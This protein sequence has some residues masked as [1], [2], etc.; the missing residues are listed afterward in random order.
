[1]LRDLVLAD[2]VFFCKRFL[3]VFRG[4]DALAEE[5]FPAFRFCCFVLTFPAYQSRIS[6]VVDSILLS[7]MEI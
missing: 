2:G 7:G 4:A 6:T 1:M 5:R 3:D